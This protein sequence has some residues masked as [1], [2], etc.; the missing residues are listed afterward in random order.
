MT[1]G[2]MYPWPEKRLFIA[3]PL[4]GVGL[5]P[6]YIPPAIARFLPLSLLLVPSAL[7]LP[8]PFQLQFA[9]ALAQSAVQLQGRQRRV[10]IDISG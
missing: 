4:V 7:Q 2:R 1:E 10:S 6:P 8:S 9:V 5:A 3:V